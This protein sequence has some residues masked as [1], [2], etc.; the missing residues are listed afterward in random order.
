MHI[1]YKIVSLSLLT[2]TSRNKKW[3]FDS[4]SSC[5]IQMSM[6]IKVHALFVTDERGV[7]YIPFPN[8]GRVVWKY[9]RLSTH[10]QVCNHHW[11]GK[12]H[13]CSM[14]LLMWKII[15]V[16]LRQYSS[17]FITSSTA[18]S[19][20]LVYCPPLNAVEP[21]YLPIQLECKWRGIQCQGIQ[22]LHHPPESFN[23]KSAS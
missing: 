3:P 9:A 17:Q 10:D 5:K 15:K 21:Q 6:K 20:L 13:C 14:H 1:P 16:A 22:S 23:A 12:T 18:M 11:N 19:S 4:V 8:P 2:S 7:I